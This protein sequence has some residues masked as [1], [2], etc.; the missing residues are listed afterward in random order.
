M[1]QLLKPVRL[2]P[3]SAPREAITV[4]AQAR[5]Q[6]LQKAPAQPRRPSATE[7]GER[8]QGDEKGK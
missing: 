4:K 5:Q 2:Q 1:S 8:G 7:A 6:H 3:R